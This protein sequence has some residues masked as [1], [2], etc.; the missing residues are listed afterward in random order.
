MT[1]LLSIDILLIAVCAWLAIGLAGLAAPRNLRFVGKMLFPLGALVGVLTGLTSL[2]FL[3][4]SAEVAVLAIG[5]P[6][7]PFHLRLDNLTAVFA[8]LVGM[9]SAGISVLPPVISGRARA[10]RRG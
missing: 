3:G 4:G 6:N 2:A 10:R 7:L 1:P 8:L 5:L 9:V